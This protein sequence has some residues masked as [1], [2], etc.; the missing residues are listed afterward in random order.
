MADEKDPYE[1]TDKADFGALEIKADD[2]E[3]IKIYKTYKHEAMQA[4]HD[5]IQQNRMNWDCYHM[6]QDF[7]Y[8]QKGQSQEFLPKM[9]IATEQLS[10]SMQ[11]GLVDMGEWFRVDNQPGINQDLMKVKPSEIERLMQR[12]LELNGFYRK[13]GDATKLGLIG[14]L[15]I[16]KIGGQWVPKP[17]YVVQKF[18]KPDGSYTKKLIKK[19]DKS[20]QLKIDLVRQQDFFPD[21]STRKMY[22]CQDIYM[23]YY[24]AEQLATG[25]NKIYDLKALKQLKS[26][27]AS[28]GADRL[29]DKARETG[30][31]ISNAKYRSVVKITE[32]W[33]NFVSPN[34][35]LMFENCVM[36]IGNDRVVLQPPTPNPYW[37]GQIPFIYTPIISVPLAEWGKALMDAPAMLNKAQNEMFNLILDGGMMSVH[38]IKQIREHWLED[39]GQI[40]AGISSGDTLRANSACPPGQTVLERVDTA[41]VPQDGIEVYNLLNQEFNV[42]ALTS[43]LRMGVQPFR[44]VKATE[45]V[46]ASQ[47]NTS[48]SNGMAKHIESSF[49][50]P[51]LE[52]GWKT[53]AQHMDDIDSNEVKALLGPQRAEAI[54]QLGPE[55]LFAD[56]VQGCKFT[57]FGISATL[58]KQKEFTKLQAL[59]QTV[60]GSPVLMEEFTREFDYAKLLGEI[61]KSL[62]IHPDKIRNDEAK[63]GLNSEAAPGQGMQQGQMP[64]M[65]SQIP[66]AGAAGNQAAGT[67]AS[68]AQPMQG[69]MQG[70]H[71]PPSRATP[72]QA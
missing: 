44:Q 10:N 55:E 19:E 62:D 71:F 56:T 33:G 37:H 7:S 57:V 23:D 67:P 35:D 29:Y 46:E 25:K 65:Q 24:Q 36:S 39:P 22:V 61:M 60:A 51:I 15:M 63:A 27:P 52:L 11:Q 17:K 21:P 6:R 47:S 43:D 34:G 53:A 18:Q 1:E 50:A 70:P 49:I 31:N 14:S 5:R 59:L 30:Q 26:E 4:R 58:N 66:Q 13:I 42:A 38:G 16:A 28:E 8:K 72:H 32:V 68:N 41:T 9:A 2:S 20:W 3:L 12:Q 48:M 45:V 54:A 64:N 69:T 40:E